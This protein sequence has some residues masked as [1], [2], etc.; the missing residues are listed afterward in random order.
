MSLVTENNFFGVNVTG[1]RNSGTVTVTT[2]ANGRITL[3]DIDTTLE[4]FVSTDKKRMVLRL[5]SKEAVDS[6]NA[7]A[8]QA[9][10][11]RHGYVIATLIEDQTAQ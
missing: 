3:S 1:E 7:P 5:I 11:A 10:E 9:D 8:S 2:A 6:A 4:G